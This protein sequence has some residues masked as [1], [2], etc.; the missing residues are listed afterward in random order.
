MWYRSYIGHDRCPIAD[1]WWQTE[2]GAIMISPIPG[3]TPTKPGSC[4]RPLPGIKV[5][6][7][8]REGTPVPAGSGG[9]LVIRRPWPS[10]LRTIYGDPERFQQQYWSQIP[11]SYFTGDGARQDED[12]Y[13]WVM[14][15][16]DDVINV[17]GHRL[18]TMEVESALVAHPRVAEAAVV[19]RPD[20][21]KGSAI[22]AFVTLQMGNEYT[23][24]LKAELRV[25]V[26]KEI[27]ALAKP[28]DI[29]FT[30]S[31]PKTRSGKIMRRLLR[32][33]AAGGEV[34]GDVTTLEDLGVLAKLRQ[35]EE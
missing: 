9:Y 23:E 34:R 4:T 5:E 12:G 26:G 14:G 32:E 29:R 33:L 18:S 22:V 17:S 19:A 2:T 20:E 6:V 15:R 13:F 30:D 24:E 3:A 8:T 21:I 10:M 25:W 7:V 16:V 27:G 35:D 31:L 11:G 1:T 28:D